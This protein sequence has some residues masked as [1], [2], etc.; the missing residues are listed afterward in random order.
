MAANQSSHEAL[1]RDREVERLAKRAKLPPYMWDTLDGLAA[2]GRFRDALLSAKQQSEPCNMD[3]IVSHERY[4]HLLAC[5]AA[6]QPANAR[7][8]ADTAR[9]VSLQRAVASKQAHIDRLMLEYC[10]DEMTPLQI[11]EWNKHQAAVTPEVEAAI[12]AAALPASAPQP[13]TQ[14]MSCNDCRIGG[15]PTPIL[16]QEERDDY[17]R[18]YG[19]AISERADSGTA[20]VPE[21]VRAALRW[22]SRTYASHAHFGTR[23]EAAI[24]AVLAAAPS[25]DGNE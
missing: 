6:A 11:E 19:F 13:A 25:P 12:D 3:V 14:R 15:C 7:A 5:E 8:V 21:D 16:C 23:H 20:K 22:L 1:Q 9:I 10:P 2:L 18:K 17:A 24:E 4:E